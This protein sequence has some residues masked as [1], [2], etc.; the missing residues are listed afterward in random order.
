MR[1]HLKYIGLVAA[2]LVTGTFATLQFSSAAQ[3]NDLAPLP[4]D[5]L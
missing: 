2:G 3:P 1:I 4:L 5:Q